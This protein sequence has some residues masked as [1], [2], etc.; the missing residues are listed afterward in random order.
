MSRQSPERQS[1]RWVSKADRRTAR[2]RRRRKKAEST[3]AGLRRLARIADLLAASAEKQANNDAARHR[4]EAQ[5]YRERAA[6]LA[7]IEETP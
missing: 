1:S 6:E 5:R 7:N 2:S 3:P 4:T